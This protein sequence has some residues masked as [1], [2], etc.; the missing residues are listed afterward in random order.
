MDSRRLS[1]IGVLSAAAVAAYVFEAMLPSPL[2]FARVG[3]SNV[4]VVI[5]LFGFDVRD[6]LLVNLVRV[7]A[8]SLLLGLTLSPAFALSLAGSMSALGVMA[9]IRWKAVPPFSVVGASCAGAATNNLVQVA[10][11]TAILAQWPVPA[12]LAGAFLLLGVGVG[13][14]TGLLAAVI[15]R[16]V[17]LER[18]GGVN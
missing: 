16:K 17:V 1:R 13:F 10:L 5:A 8:G 7:L 14:L 6:A 3:V 11:F 4:F 2:P 12:G 9:L 18:L 15:L